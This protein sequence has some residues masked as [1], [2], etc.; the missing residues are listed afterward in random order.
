MFAAFIYKPAAAA[1]AL[2]QHA[3][4]FRE[5]AERKELSMRYQNSYSS[6][7]HASPADRSQFLTGVA[8]WLVGGL[9][10]TAIVN[11]ASVLF[12]VPA[13]MGLGQWG[14]LAV[15][16]G[17]MFLSQSVA[18][19]MVYGESKLPGFVLGTVA[20]GISF[21]FILFATLFG[22]GD[23]ADGLLLVGQCM[24]MVVL[25]GAA[26]L[27]YVFTEKREFSL[28]RSGLSMMGIPMLVL[29]AISFIW[30]IGGIAGI[31]LSAV[32]VAVSAGSLLYKLNHVV[33]TMDTSQTMEAGYELTLSIVVLLWNLLALFSRLRRR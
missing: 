19:N 15:I 32:F 17:S 24:G 16:Y 25:S 7:L 3:R 27:V 20:Q 31:A 33:H 14:I 26:M 30:P 5:I 29:M 23:I 1:G 2:P 9:T 10:L 13:V 8:G 6:V 11:I 22:V 21:G 4:G 12:V 18:K 28:L